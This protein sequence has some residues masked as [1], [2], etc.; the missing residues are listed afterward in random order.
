[1]KNMT[2][3]KADCNNC[4]NAGCAI[5][6]NQFGAIRPDGK[7]ANIRKQFN[8]DQN[9]RYYTPPTPLKTPLLYHL[10]YNDCTDEVAEL[11]LRAGLR[12]KETKQY[13]YFKL[14]VV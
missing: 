2:M 9:C 5:P 1:M 7:K 12:F 8:Y 4:T 3:N 14:Q 6:Q 10:I 13:P 11:L